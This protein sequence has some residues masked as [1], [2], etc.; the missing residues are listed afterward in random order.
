MP[1]NTNAGPHL[2]FRSWNAA[3]LARLIGQLELDQVADL[4]GHDTSH[5]LDAFVVLLFA[6]VVTTARVAISFGCGLFDDA[7]HRPVHRGWQGMP[8]YRQ[9]HK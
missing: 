9:Q 7:H 1:T 5:L 2:L 8:G 4:V 3:G 6:Q